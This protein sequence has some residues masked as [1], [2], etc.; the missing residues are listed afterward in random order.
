MKKWKRTDFG[1][2]PSGLSNR[3][4][5]E[6]EERRDLLKPIEQLLCDVHEEINH[7]GRPVEANIAHANKRMVSLMARVAISNDTASNRLL[8]LTWILVFLT[9]AIAALTL[10]M[11]VKMTKAP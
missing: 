5:A 9:L 4:L 1:P 3:E 11:A 6:E 10:L 7:P 8:W 2:L